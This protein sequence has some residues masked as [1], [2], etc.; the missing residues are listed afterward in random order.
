MIPDT[1]QRDGITTEDAVEINRG[2]IRASDFTCGAVINYTT[3]IVATA[4]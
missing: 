4:T 3:L 2:G 1:P